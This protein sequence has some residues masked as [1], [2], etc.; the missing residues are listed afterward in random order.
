MLSDLVT[1]FV[2]LKESMVILLRERVRVRSLFLIE[3][4]IRK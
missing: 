1:Y 4:A 3:A 2:S